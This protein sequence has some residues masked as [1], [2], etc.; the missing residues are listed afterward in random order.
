MVNLCVPVHMLVRSVGTGLDWGELFGEWF[1]HPYWL[2]PMF[3]SWSMAAFRT[4]VS[5]MEMPISRP[6]GYG[7][8]EAPASAL[9]VQ[10]RE[11]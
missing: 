1:I 11:D 6:L 7:K 10:L 5:G 4:G 3:Q 8:H 9:S 2:T